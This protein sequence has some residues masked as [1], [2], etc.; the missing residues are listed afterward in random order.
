MDPDVTPQNAVSH[1]GLFY[2]LKKI[3]SKN[4][5]KMKNTPDV[6]KTESGLIQM[7]RMGISIGHELVKCQNFT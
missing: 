1:L 4:E 6:P 7:I 2:L 3:S 5:I